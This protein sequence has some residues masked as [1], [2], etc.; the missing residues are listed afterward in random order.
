M[1]QKLWGYGK[2]DE[3]VRVI[4]EG[5]TPVFGTHPKALFN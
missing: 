2:L 1:I 5:D 3:T 4:D